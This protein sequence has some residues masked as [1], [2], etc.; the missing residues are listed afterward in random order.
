VCD[1]PAPGE[2]YCFGC[3]AYVHFECDRLGMEENCNGNPYAHLR[4][5]VEERR[6]K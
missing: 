1:K 6:E 2:L 5:G 4:V 3:G